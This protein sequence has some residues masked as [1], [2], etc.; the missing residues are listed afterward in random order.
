MDLLG[1]YGTILVDPPWVYEFA[2]R[3]GPR[4]N[5][6]PG[7]VPSLMPSG[8]THGWGQ[9]SALTGVQARYDCLTREQLLGL[10][11]DAIAAKDALLWCWATNKML[12]LAFELVVAWGFDY[13][14]LITWR[15]VTVN[16]KLRTGMGYWARGATEHV[17]LAGRGKVRPGINNLPTVFDAEVQAHSAKP[18]WIR[19]AA[20]RHGP[21]PYLEM[22]AR[23]PYEG[24]E[25]WG[26]EVETDIWLPVPEVA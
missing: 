14:T 1:R 23:K 7:V 26:D 2:T 6:S 22:F 9:H 19:D 24:F 10:P 20:L 3:K 13:K 15:K 16:G 4:R 18:D 5:D 21:G 8:D 12:P 11:V 17:L 25:V